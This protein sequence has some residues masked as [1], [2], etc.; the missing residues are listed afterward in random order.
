MCK[1][2]VYKVKKRLIKADTTNDAKMRWL[3][4][5][6][7]QEDVDKVLDTAREMGCQ[8]AHDI[9]EFTEDNLNEVLKT[10]CSD[11]KDAFAKGWASEVNYSDKY[12]AVETDENISSFND[13]SNAIDYLDTASKLLEQ[14]EM[15]INISQHI[16]EAVKE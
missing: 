10:L 5:E 9:Y 3:A 8:W 16:D 4:E 6:L 11:F 2:K 14:P 7:K 12:F 1:R 15:A 13:L